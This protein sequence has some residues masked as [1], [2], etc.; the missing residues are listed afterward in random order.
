MIIP[1]LI[2]S[3]SPPSRFSNLSIRVIEISIINRKQILNSNTP[4]RND[5]SENYKCPIITL[6]GKVKGQTIKKHI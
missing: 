4:S 2:R 6:G 3:N 5:A 1:K